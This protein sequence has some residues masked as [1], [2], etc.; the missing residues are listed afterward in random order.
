[1][2]MMKTV[3]ICTLV[4][5][6]GQQWMTRILFALRAMCCCFLFDQWMCLTHF[7][8]VL[9]WSV[10]F[11]A[12]THN[13]FWRHS[14]KDSHVLHVLQ[15]FWEDHICVELCVSLYAQTTKTHHIMVVR[16][17]LRWQ[18]QRLTRKWKVQTWHPQ[19]QICNLQV[20]YQIKVHLSMTILTLMYYYMPTCDDIS[21]KVITVVVIIVTIVITISM[22]IV[23]MQ[24]YQLYNVLKH[25][26]KFYITYLAT[27]FT[28][29]TNIAMSTSHE[30]T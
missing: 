9:T 10:V 12:I 4:E 17:K 1:M 26:A 15:V 20:T 25:N 2:C 16:Y 6:S 5:S 30:I 24:T 19:F 18:H 14:L 27:L 13:E 28:W 29:Y 23:T 7:D 3:Q 21:R 8:G 22:T 11:V